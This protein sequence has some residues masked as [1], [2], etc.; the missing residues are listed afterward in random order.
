M[1]TTSSPSVV[2]FAD[3]SSRP[4]ASAG[5]VGRRVAT[6]RDLRAAAG[7]PVPIYDVSRHS[8]RSWDVADAVGRAVHAVVGR[9]AR[10]AQTSGSAASHWGL[11]DA[12]NQVVTGRQFGRLD[13]SRILVTGRALQ[14]ISLYLPLPP[15]ELIGSEVPVSPGR[16]DLAW[17]DPLRGVF[18]DELKT[19]RQLTGG[20]D[21]ATWTQLRRYIDA[22]LQEYADNFVGIRVLALGDP[23]SCMFVDPD[24]LPIPLSESPLAS[25]GAGRMSPLSAESDVPTVGVSS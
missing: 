13:R 6:F 7:L 21:A 3:T 8:E 23:R 17:R 18:F 20:F 11:K 24:G 9:V 5:R 2:S 10:E 1:E 14:Y 19:G 16:V 4:Q 25:I 22:G 15:I 12:V